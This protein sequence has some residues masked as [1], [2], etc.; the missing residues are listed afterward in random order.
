MRIIILKR[1]WNLPLYFEKITRTSKAEA[2]NTRH[3]RIPA[4]IISI[5]VMSRRDFAKEKY[6][7]L[8]K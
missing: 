4:P 2:M 3:P 7:E 1:R 5:S 8:K 6:L